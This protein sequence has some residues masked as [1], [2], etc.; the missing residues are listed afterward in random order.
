MRP[1]GRRQ[2]QGD[3]FVPVTRSRHG[4]EIT[5]DQLVPDLLIPFIGE[6]RLRVHAGQGVRRNNHIGGSDLLQGGGGIFIPDYYSRKENIVEEYRL[7]IFRGKSI[8]AGVKVPRE[9]SETHEWIRSFDAGWRIQYDGFKSRRE[10]R[11]LASSAV[12]AL[13]LDFGA[14]DLGRLDTGELIV[15]E[16]NRAPGIEGGSVEAYVGGVKR[17]IEE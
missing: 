9:D 14:V 2:I 13:G 12:T 7:H 4:V 11:D 15:L 1:Q 6:I 10:M 5:I 16:V 3:L 17:W 8:R